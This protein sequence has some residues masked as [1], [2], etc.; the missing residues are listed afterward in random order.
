M[1]KHVVIHIHHEEKYS[2]F[3]RDMAAFLVD[4]T[5]QRL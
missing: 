5:K 2:F 4:I 1:V 3:A